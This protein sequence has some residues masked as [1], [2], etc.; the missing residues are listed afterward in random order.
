MAARI[1]RGAWEVPALF[2]A[3]ETAG[4]VRAEEMWRTF[5]MGI[6]MVVV[7]PAAAA[8]LAGASAAGLPVIPLGEIVDARDG[9]QVVL[10]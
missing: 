1:E 7:V 6:G 3:L 5:N 10:R 2:T 4:G 8:H 9:H